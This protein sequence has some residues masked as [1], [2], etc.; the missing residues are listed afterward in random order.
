MRQTEPLICSHRAPDDDFICRKYGV[1]YPMRDCN[2][3]VL[4]RTFDG[5]VDCFQGRLN[6][7]GR[8]GAR[9]T[10]VAPGSRSLIAFPARHDA[11]AAVLPTLNPRKP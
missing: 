11:T 10:D 8:S 3:R 5:C 6:L 9:G 1:W 4:H 7:R 2:Y